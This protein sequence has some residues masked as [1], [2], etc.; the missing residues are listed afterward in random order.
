MPLIISSY[1]LACVPVG[2]GKTTSAR[3]ISSQAAVP[4][5]YVPLEAV[6]SKW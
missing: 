2:T 4:L 1:P 3:I 6:M 5:V